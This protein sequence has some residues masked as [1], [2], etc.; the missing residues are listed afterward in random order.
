MLYIV[1]D[2]LLRRDGTA[3]SQQVAIVDGQS[4]MTYA[5]LLHQSL[6]YAALLRNS[7]VAR[8]DRVGI[9]LRRSAEAAA[10]LFG[11]HLA[12]GVAVVIHEQ[13]RAR[14]VRYILEHSEASLL[15]TDS[16]QLL[17]AGEPLV[18][19][20]R[21]V[22][23]DDLR[24]PAP[25]ASPERTIAA[26]HALIIYTSGSTGLPK[27]VVLTHDN[28]CAGARIVADYLKLTE[29]DIIIS[30]LPFSFDYGLN[31]LLT[32]MLVGGT[33]VIQR[34]LFPPDI[35]RTLQ[36]EHVTG[37][38][39]VPTLWV[40]LTQDHSPFLKRTFP[41][42]RYI[43][44]SGGR[45]PESIVRQIRERHP[46]VSVYLMYGLTEA[47]RST[48]LPPEEVDRRPSSIGKAIPNVEILVINEEGRPC[49]ADEVGELVHRGATVA[50]GYWRD[51]VSTAKVFRPHP[52][53]PTGNGRPEMVVYSGDLVQQDAEGYL[54]YVGRRDQLIKS[55]G[56][57][58]SPEE[59]EA[60]IFSS[61]L[62]D[63]VVAFAVSRDEVVDDIVVAVVSR[64]GL[65]VPD[66]R[67]QQFCQREMPDYMLP[68]VIWR[69]DQ[70][71]LTTSGKPDRVQL[72]A[73]YLDTLRSS[74][75]AA[76]AARTA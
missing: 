66:D 75:T 39:G 26:D 50:K 58:V 23:I 69:L 24:L 57:R 51:P 19:E 27:G 71:P 47:F 70:L 40:Q 72:K 32:A 31:Q 25:I 63:H 30:V 59:I 1:P 52:F 60:A 2:L 8:G 18:D 53:D 9:Y 42:L 10:A 4:R 62:V 29:Q 5:D 21:L 28:L 12:G 34:S 73:M 33:L 43:T 17:Y 41:E 76:G 55:S 54:Y 22:R 15:V 11:V 7:G 14:Q 36:R 20:S 67:L 38:A 49:Q 13:L 46:H 45:L 61:G 65:G 16:R 56:F 3:T 35:C 68:R 64:D 6:R 37:M 44:N 74:A 48:Y